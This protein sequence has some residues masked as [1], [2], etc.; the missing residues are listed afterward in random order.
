MIWEPLWNLLARVEV[1]TFMPYPVL[2]WHLFAHMPIVDVG[3]HI[4][5]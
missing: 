1:E 4:D 5:Q 2:G 3:W